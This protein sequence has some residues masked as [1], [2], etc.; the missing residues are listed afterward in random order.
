MKTQYPQ[1]PWLDAT[2]FENRTNSPPRNSESTQGSTSLGVGMGR[3]SWPVQRFAICWMRN[4]LLL[5]RS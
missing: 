5:G 4:F 3:R 1:Y 2:Y